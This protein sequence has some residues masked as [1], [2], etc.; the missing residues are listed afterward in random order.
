MNGPWSLA[1]K[2]ALVCGSSRG[3]GR[4][5]ALALAELGCAVTGLARDGARLTALER[6][7]LAA[8]A[9]RTATVVADLDDRPALAASVGGHLAEWPAEILVIC[10]GGPKAGPILAATDEELSHA[11]GRNVL[12]AQALVRAVLPGMKAA[13]YGRIVTVLSTSVKEPI[14]NLGV[15]NTVRGAMGAWAKTLSGELPPGITVNN[16]LP[17]YTDTERLSE[18]ASGAASRTGKSIDEVR[19]GWA[20]LSPEK[21]IADPAEIARVV[22]FL[23]S[24]AASFVRGQSIAADGGRSRGI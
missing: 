9:P 19:A 6:E 4:A 8:G 20:A 24:P 3:I 15:G 11:F 21:R 1:G 13:G 23:C 2:H 10:T 7:L 5:T 18:L 17:G 22:A 12:A 16:V 14:D